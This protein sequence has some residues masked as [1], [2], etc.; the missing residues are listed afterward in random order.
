[1][2]TSL[3]SL[4]ADPAF[5]VVAVLTIALGIAANTAIFSVVDAILLRPLPYPFAERIVQV[6]T[7]TPEDPKE[8][9]SPP[10][11]LDFQRAD[12]LS[13]LAGYREDALTIA[14]QEGDPVRELGA[15][16][17]VDY[18]DVF[19]TAAAM[20]R[21]FSRTVDGNSTEPV[22]VLS[23]K[24]WRDTLASDPSIVGRR[25]R[26]NGVP[27]TVVGVMPAGFDYPI[28]TRAW[29]LSKLPVPPAPMDV[30]GDLLHERSIHY[31][32]AVG[33]L[34]PGESLSQAEARLRVVA[35]D[36]GRRQPKTNAGRGV[37]LEPL[38][39]RI[40]G[41]VRQALLVL[42]GAVGVVLL[43]ACANVASLLLARA[44][45][46]Q[47]EIAIRVA[48]GASRGRIIRQLLS[49][50]L[51]LASIGGVLGLL[52]GSWAV[53]LLVSVIPEGVP[54]VEAVALDWRVAAA[55]VALTFVSG[56][57]VGLLPSL[58]ASRADGFARLR[59]AGDRATA[60][61]RRRARTRSVLVVGELALTLVL[62]VTAGLLANSFLRLARVDPGF[63]IESL[64][65][66][67][68]P[69]PQAKYADRKAQA[70]FYERLLDGLKTRGEITRAAVAF[71]NPLSGANA[72]GSF[73][74]E[75]R[76]AATRAEQPRANIGSISPE[77]F[78]TM[79]IALLSG[80]HF[81]DQDRDV[82]PAPIIVNSAFARRYF[83]GE[84]AVGKRLR[85][86]NPDDDWMMIVGVAADSHN[87]G[88]DVAPEPLLY[89]PY[90][91]FVLPFMSVVVQSAGGAPAVASAVRAEVKRL[92]PDLPIDTVQPM[93]DVIRKS[94]SEPRFRTLLLGVF[95]LTALVLAAI[96]VYGLISYSVA[97]Q[98]REI[99]IRV[100]LGARPAQV[101]VPIVREGMILAVIGVALGLCG[102]LAAT[103]IVAAFLY[104]VE[105]SDPA[106]F[107]AL[108]ALLL[109]VAL[110]ASYIPSRRALKVDPLTALRA[111]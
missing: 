33:R 84:N 17:T 89:I 59:D 92:D 67:E 97:Q 40:V 86:G 5:T 81:T 111:E 51:L 26:V 36:L 54:F 104:G 74:I 69:L 94:V 61:G 105:A 103:K 79:G 45:R 15:L 37:Q 106:T 16:V 6:W 71:P 20:G 13:P 64:T 31:F 60:G 109:I 35:D 9:H 46:R 42:L 11:F 25:L 78:R 4:G 80:R 68:M 2:R 23:D 28:G 24:V 100:A 102:S 70:G 27:H 90:Q 21:T 1:M 49:E 52:A 110:L 30:E 72:V 95:A 50:S 38:H 8:S 55:A 19:G 85:F 88:L 56:L 93:R 108:A 107:A 41:D 12:A 48:L 96:G 76:P 101:V 3:R 75:G 82:A 66:V 73:T 58:Q 53:P 10:D 44:S 98:T 87:K 29:V 57:L 62:L 99:G 77:Y 65:L 39:R 18:F 91:Y 7:T 22:V 14:P 43:I 32:L 34:K 47:R 83:P 63:A